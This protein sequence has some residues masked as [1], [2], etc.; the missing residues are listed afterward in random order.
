[1]FEVYGGRTRQ[2]SEWV[3]RT[4]KFLSNTVYIQAPVMD[5]VEYDFLLSR[6][7]MKQLKLNFYWN[8]VVPVS[9]PPECSTASDGTTALLR[10]IKSTDDVSKVYL[11]LVCVGGYPPCTPR[12]QVLLE[13]EDKSVVRKKNLTT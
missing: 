6:P 8:N 1:M 5:G 7:D 11:E 10:T 12:F 3:D 2:H 13:L 4:V 9:S